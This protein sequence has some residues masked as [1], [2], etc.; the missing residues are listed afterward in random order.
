MSGSGFNT[1]AVTVDYETQMT[2]GSQ[3]FLFQLS[4][5]DGADCISDIS[6]LY[7]PREG[8]QSAMVGGLGLRQ[9]D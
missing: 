4:R 5:D 2:R 8:G 6:S 9:A 7:N 1:F 3:A